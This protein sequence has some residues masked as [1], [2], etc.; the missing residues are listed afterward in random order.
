MSQNDGSEGQTLGEEEQGQP[1]GIV[2]KED[3]SHNRRQ[4]LIE[5]YRERTFQIRT[6]AH[7]QLVAGNLSQ[8]DA[9]RYYRG[10]VESYL[11]QV[12]PV[13]ERDDIEWS[14]N[15][16]HAVD[17][18]TV[19]FQP[20][21]ALVTYARENVIRL[22]D[23]QSVP[24]PTVRSVT[25]LRS[26]LDLPAPLSVRYSVVVRDGGGLNRA[27]EIVTKEI[28]RSIMDSALQLT[29]KALADADLGIN[30]GE[31]TNQTKITDK[32]I[33]EVDEWREQNVS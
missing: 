16:L 3:F 13:L 32:T 2:D 20:P 24:T 15:Y 21:E 10:A 6:E 30:I 12:L 9:R 17:L 25:G 31:K 23:G 27:D 33:E 28:P 29:D 19:E 26:I 5:E 22:P 8:R 7:G 11:L 18:G 4:Q 14:Q 1:S